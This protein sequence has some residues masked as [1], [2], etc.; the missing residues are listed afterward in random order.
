M[1]LFFSVQLVDMKIKFDDLLE[2]KEKV[3]EKL[4][5]VEL[6]EVNRRMARVS[7]DEGLKKEQELMK[8]EQVISILHFVGSNPKLAN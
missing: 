4:E 7:K 6:Y 2:Q 3:D 8:S 1:L 5:A